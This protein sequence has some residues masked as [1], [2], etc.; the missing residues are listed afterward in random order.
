VAACEE[1]DIILICETWAHNEISNSE[2]EIQGYSIETDLRKDRDDTQH[3]IGGGLLIFSK[4]GILLR[5]NDRYD[6]YNFNQF[7]SFTIMLKTPVEITLI[8]RPPNS[9]TGNMD[10][11]CKLLENAAQEAIF[12]GDFNTPDVNWRD[13]QAGPRYKKF[14]ESVQ[15]ADM[16]QLVNFKTHDRGNTLDLIL[17]NCSE[18][19]LSVEEAG[20]LGNSDHCAII[21]EMVLKPS[22]SDKSINR[23]AW[24][25][26]DY[27]S[28]KSELRETDWERALT[29]TVEDDW[30]YFKGR[31]HDCIRKF[32]PEQKSFKNQRPRWLTQE[33]VKLI[34]KKKA[35]WK[36]YRLYGTADSSNI[37]KLLEREVKSKI[38]KSKRKMEKQLAKGDDKNNRKFA[39]YIKSK[40]KSKTGMAP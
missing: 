30:R 39:S 3:G 15:R 6:K 12:I 10:E 8:Y 1:P 34:R 7:S 4:N 13:E 31:I 17:T 26:A 23:L 35:A 32:V 20:K 22:K 2:L 40:T 16:T 9:G 38:Q 19:I 33:I 37:Y 21:F 28:I 27:Q 18:R 14:L 11:L 25:R 24:K 36:Q 29:G 5:K